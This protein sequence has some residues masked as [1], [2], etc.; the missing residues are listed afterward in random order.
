MRDID[1]RNQPFIAQPAQMR[2][3]DGLRGHIKP[4]RRFIQHQDIVR[5]ERG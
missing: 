4:G 2:D 3:H 1:H 5:A